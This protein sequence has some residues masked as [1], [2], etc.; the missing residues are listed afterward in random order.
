MMQFAVQTLELSPKDQ[1]GQEVW[2][3]FVAGCISDH[4]EHR[5]EEGLG[6]YV[7]VFGGT[8][9]LNA[10]NQALLAVEYEGAE[11]GNEKKKG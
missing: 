1:V 9:K 8:D 4:E 10:S 2:E 3:D 6:S 7:Y 11:K 5:P